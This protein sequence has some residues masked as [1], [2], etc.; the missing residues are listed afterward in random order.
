MITLEKLKVF[1]KYGGDPDGLIRVGS[2]REKDILDEDGWH[3]ID[4]L[5]WEI[6]L[7][8]AGLASKEF[9]QR[10]KNKM[11]ELVKSPEAKEKILQFLRKNSPSN[12]VPLLLFLIN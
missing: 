6:Y 4:V 7:V 3:K 10:V 5:T 11:N 2:E 8:N 12:P 1:E 9:E